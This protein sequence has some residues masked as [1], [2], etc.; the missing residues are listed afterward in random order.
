M[1]V[2]IR[3]CLPAF[4]IASSS[5]AIAADA[6]LVADAIR[7]E[8]TRRNDDKEG[9]PLPLASHWCCGKHPLSEGW[10]PAH[11]L[12]LIEEGHYLL[13]WFA[14]PPTEAQLGK[15]GLDAFLK[16]YE[17]PMKR[18]AELKLPL[19]IVG[20]QWECLL[21]AEPYIKLEPE[22]NP[23]VVTVDGKVR[24]EVCPFGPVELWDEVGR[25]WTDNPQLKRLQ[26][27]YPDPPLVIFL[28]NNEHTKLRWHKAEESRRYLAKYGKGKDDDFKR[29][30]VAEGWIERYRALQKGMRDGLASGAWRERALFVGYEAFGPD[31]MGRW[32]GWPN[33]SLHS[34][35]RIS[36]APLMWDGGSPSYYTH[37]WNPSR[38]YTVWSPQLEFMNLAF[39]LR[40]AWKLNPNFWFEF[41]V[42]DGYDGPRREKEY[43]SPRTLYR[44]K[45][46][47]YNPERYGGFV[48]FGIWLLRPRAVREFRGWV[49]PAEEGLPYFMA[50]AEAVDRVHRSDVLRKFWRQG[51]L[52]PN[53]ARQHHYQ[54]GIPD[55]WKGEDRWFLLDASVNPQEFPWELHWE[56]AVYS[57]ALVM[58]QAPER[59]WL[60]YAHSPVKERKGV[61]LTIPDYQQI[62]VDTSP[63]GVFWLV[64]EKAGRVEGVK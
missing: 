41:S 11:Q 39:M 25:K 43:P 33:Y 27:W 40:E 56:V 10:A 13:P 54:A 5:L 38:D 2:F 4:L 55:E 23:N 19:T 15:E 45:G 20:T 29:R 64:D 17:E 36:P 28:S 1:T 50:I 3:S 32:G 47:A 60:V 30:V 35:G 61:K 58:G 53:R 21:S 51:E 46:Q 22:K 37:D 34:K 24:K 57:L 18:A 31:H 52:V 8:A 26:A 63:A 12:R 14:H 42:W 16:Y 7:A 49:F 62:T 6:K 48:Q 59:Q 44:M 9:R